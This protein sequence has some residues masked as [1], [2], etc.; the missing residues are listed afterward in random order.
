MNIEEETIAKN[1]TGF[2]IPKYF[3]MKQIWDSLEI[4]RRVRPHELGKDFIDSAS[5]LLNLW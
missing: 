3:K 1:K 2:G 5:V 4:F